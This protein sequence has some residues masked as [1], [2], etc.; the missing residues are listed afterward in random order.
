MAQLPVGKELRRH[1]GHAVPS[2]PF[3]RLGPSYPD[4]SVL[5]ADTTKMV[6]PADVIPR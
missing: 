2:G 1:A 4:A 5:F 3:K 6:S